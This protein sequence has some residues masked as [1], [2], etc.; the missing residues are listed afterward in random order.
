MERSLELREDLTERIRLNK[1]EFLEKS[2]VF[3]VP[4]EFNHVIDGTILKIDEYKYW[5]L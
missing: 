2:W 4:A 1:N 3:C 5:I